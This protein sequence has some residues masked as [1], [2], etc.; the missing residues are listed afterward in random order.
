VDADHGTGEPLGN[1]TGPISVLG[2]GE[3]LS[4]QLAVAMR[5]TDSTGKRD[6]RED[7]NDKERG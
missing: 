7:K 5:A 3:T 1:D 4:C 2:P 6:V